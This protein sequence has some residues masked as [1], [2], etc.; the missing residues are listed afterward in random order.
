MR[1]SLVNSVTD[2]QIDFA[3]KCDLVDWIRT[4]SIF[5]TDCICR[6]W[7]VHRAMPPK[8]YC[9]RYRLLPRICSL[10]EYIVKHKLL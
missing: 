4:H 6:R 9:T 5:L 7:H 10:K 2:K 1:Y 3:C 8:Q